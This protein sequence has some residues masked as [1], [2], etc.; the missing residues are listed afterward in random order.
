MIL[1]MICNSVK[2]RDRAEII[3]GGGVNDGVEGS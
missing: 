2:L 1:P 3:I